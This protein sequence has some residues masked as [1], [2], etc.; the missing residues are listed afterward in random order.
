M[1]LK[2]LRS[3]RKKG[4]FELYFEDEVHFQRNTSIV[5]AWSLKGE[6]VEIKS[7]PVKEKTS[8]L[9]ALGADNGQL[10]TMEAKQFCALSFKKF[11][12]KI[13]NTAQTDKKIVLVLDNA[14]FHHA[15]INKEF[16]ASIGDKLE[17]MF[18]PAYAPELNPI[19]Y[20]WKKTRRDVTHNRYFE[21]HEEQKESLKKYFRKFVRPNKILT[22]LS[23][24]I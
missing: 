14:R 17:L 21:S 1:L 6:T 4:K 23:A 15:K 19:E 7:P 13:L 2:K 3:L 12:I 22:K 20:L 9:G 11:I 8:F 16:F 10:I 18:L 5:R 24:N